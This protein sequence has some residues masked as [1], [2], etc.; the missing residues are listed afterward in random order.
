VG[1]SEAKISA[2]DPSE[3]GHFSEIGVFR[4]LEVNMAQNISADGDGALLSVF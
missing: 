3:T 2:A 1:L 4:E